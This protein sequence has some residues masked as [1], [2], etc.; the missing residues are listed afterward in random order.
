LA[1]A[2]SAGAGAARWHLESGGDRFGPAELS[3]DRLRAIAMPVL[4]EG[5]TVGLEV[6]NQD[7]LRTDLHVVVAA[8]TLVELARDAEHQHHNVVVEVNTSQALSTSRKVGVGH[9]E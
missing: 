8:G 2:F 3:H 5:G 6:S 9:S 1:V 4:I 7:M